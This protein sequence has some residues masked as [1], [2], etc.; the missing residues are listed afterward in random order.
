MRTGQCGWANASARR[1]T[2][3]T[4]APHIAAICAAACPNQHRVGRARLRITAL[5]PQVEFVDRG[6]LSQDPQPLHANLLVWLIV[7][8]RFQTFG[9]SASGHHAL[10]WTAT[11]SE[12][13]G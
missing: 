9:D 5:Q 12:T 13:P 10:S 3:K 11:V 6:D 8:P 7:F 4:R 2:P 1:V